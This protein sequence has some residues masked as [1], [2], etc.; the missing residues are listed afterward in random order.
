M[1]GLLQWERLT[2]WATSFGL[3]PRG[4]GKE[5]TGPAQARWVPKALDNGQCSNQHRKC[6]LPLRPSLHRNTPSVREPQ[7][8]ESFCLHSDLEYPG[9]SIFYEIAFHFS[10]SPLRAITSHCNVLCTS[11]FN[12]VKVFLCCLFFTWPML[13][14]W[15]KYPKS[16]LVP[17][18]GFVHVCFS[19]AS[20]GEEERDEHIAAQPCPLPSDQWL[21]TANRG[22][23]FFPAGHQSLPGSGP[24]I[25][26]SSVPLL[27]LST[28]PKARNHCCSRM[29]PTFQPSCLCLPQTLCGEW[30]VKIRV[31]IV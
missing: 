9:S 12:L 19:V 5:W 3:W 27:F 15:I 4:V 31:T 6:L 8:Q 10:S 14:S 13:S 25:L 21:P 26:P 20:N 16:A 29:Y 22:S 11:I 30:C 18:V 17:S 23:P 7:C 2:L 28:H 24:T 1:L